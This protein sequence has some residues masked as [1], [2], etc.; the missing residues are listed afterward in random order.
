MKITTDKENENKDD[1]IVVKQHKLLGFI[2]ILNDCI[3]KFSEL[4]TE[5]D[6]DEVVSEILDIISNKSGEYNREYMLELY[7]AFAKMFRDDD[8]MSCIVFNEDISIIH[9]SRPYSE[10]D[11][12][13]RASLRVNET[14]NADQQKSIAELTDIIWK[15]VMDQYESENDNPSEFILEMDSEQDKF[16][17]RLVHSEYF[18]F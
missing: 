2:S 1:V 11:I 6:R 18:S 3:K 10:E 15:D 4:H 14:P 7:E 17:I 13:E 8:G 9:D 12:S 16:K 5:N